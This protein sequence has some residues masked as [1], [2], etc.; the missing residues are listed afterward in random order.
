MAPGLARDGNSNVILR[1]LF[2]AIADQAL[3]LAQFLPAD[4]L[5]AQE[6]HKEFRSGTREVPGQ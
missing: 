1:Q 5:I 6:L 4:A 2:T 3:K